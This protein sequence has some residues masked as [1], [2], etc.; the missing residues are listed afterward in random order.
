[1]EN[2]ASSFTLHQKGK[3][4]LEADS[5]PSTTGSSIFLLPCAITWTIFSQGLLARA[6][7][8]A[9]L[10]PRLLFSINLRSAFPLFFPHFTSV[11]NNESTWHHVPIGNFAEKR[12]KKSIK[13][14]QVFWIMAGVYGTVF[15]LLYLAYLAHNEGSTK[16]AGS[17]SFILFFF[18]HSSFIS[19]PLGL[20]L[21]IKRLFLSTPSILTRRDISTPD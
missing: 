12:R 3:E 13:P 20:G 9:L 1:M 16:S 18:S 11:A 6:F 17:T 8:Y 10:P 21:S 7:M 2:C 5:C 4:C 15:G 14:D 19:P